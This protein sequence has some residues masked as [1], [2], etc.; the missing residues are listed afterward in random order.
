[1][2]NPKFNA[3]KLEFENLEVSKEEVKKDEEAI[4]FSSKLV[5]CFGEIMRAHN[6]NVPPSHPLQLKQNYPK[7]VSLLELKKVYERAGNDCV[8]AEL[9]GKT[10]GQWAL[11]RVNMFLRLK[12]GEKMN[13]VESRISAGM[14]IDISEMWGPSEKDFKK[15]D[16]LIKEYKLD[17][18]F[19][20]SEELY[21]EGYKKTYLDWE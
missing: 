16:E 9:A 8:A 21:L 5:K 7:K 19:T 14:L 18:D 17:Y 4:A 6:A 12:L 3:N 13:I 2:G 15:A 20:S 10:C 1:M 11:A